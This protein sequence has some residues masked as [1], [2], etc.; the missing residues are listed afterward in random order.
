MTT[1]NY[2]KNICVLSTIVFLKQ[3][4]LK[5]IIKSREFCKIYSFCSDVKLSWDDIENI[6]GEINF[7]NEKELFE[8]IKKCSTIKK[9]E[10]YEKKLQ[11]ER[12]DNYNFF[13]KLKEDKKLNLRSPIFQPLE[14]LSI[15][16]IHED[17]FVSKINY[18][19][20]ICVLKYENEYGDQCL[21][22]SK[23]LDKLK[24]IPNIPRVIYFD[25]TIDET[26]YISEPFGI[27]FINAINLFQ[28]NVQDLKKYKDQLIT[29][30]KNIHQREVVHMDIKPE[31]LILFEDQLYLIDFGLSCKINKKRKRFFGTKAFAS[32]NAPKPNSL[33]IPQDDFISAKLTFRELNKII[34][35]RD[36]IYDD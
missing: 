14:I 20:K 25:N 27:D 4:K 19:N 1:L 36:Y 29:I 22:E 6:Q 11:S 7:N 30:L 31:N 10:K 24:D 13:C 26:I 5:K 9:I 33:C 18:K 21:N 23:I 34:K 12:V 2:S 16:Q 17:S 32:E 8:T 15:L 3:S 28:I 35:E